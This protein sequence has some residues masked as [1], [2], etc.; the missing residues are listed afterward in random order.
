ML[1]KFTKDIGRFKAGATHDYP[2]GV[3]RKMA[4][5]SKQK[6]DSFTQ[7][8]EFNSGLQNPL[9]GPVKIRTRLGSTH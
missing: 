2:T 1:R 3:W 8:I 4:A 6:L 5:D 9:R 7:P